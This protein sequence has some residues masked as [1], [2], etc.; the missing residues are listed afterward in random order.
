MSI[1]GTGLPPV[2]ISSE[3][4]PPDDESPVI[5][6]R[7]NHYILRIGCAFRELERIIWFLKILGLLGRQ[8]NPYVLEG[9]PNGAEFGAFVIPSG[10]ELLLERVSVFDGACSRRVIYPQSA[11][12]GSGRDAAVQSQGE[13]QAA[14]AQAEQRTREFSRGPNQVEQTIP[15]G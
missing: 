15:H 10:A 7:R 5:T 6:V 1:G 14:V 11:L 3:Y 13:A 12:T 8:Q 2:W 9:Y 4:Q